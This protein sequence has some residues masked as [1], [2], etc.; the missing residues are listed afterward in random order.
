MPSISHSH[1]KQLWNSRKTWHARLI[2]WLIYLCLSWRSSTE[3]NQTSKRSKFRP[4]HLSWA[5][6]TSFAINIPNS[7]RKQLLSSAFSFLLENFTFGN[8]IIVLNVSIHNRVHDWNGHGTW[9][10]SSALK[11]GRLFVCV[12][13]LFSFRLFF[14]LL[15]SSF[16]RNFA[17]WKN[18]EIKI[19]TIC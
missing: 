15:S 14:F 11:F 6:S 2:D 18:D 9:C 3:T 8:D 1:R 10:S 5:G 17:C 13:L 16:Y 4:I 19:L 7:G 12:L